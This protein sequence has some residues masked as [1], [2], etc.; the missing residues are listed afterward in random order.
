MNRNVAVE[1]AE[2]QRL[3]RELEEAETYTMTLR[4]VIVDVRDHLAAGNV[5]DAL[6]MLNEA[7]RNFDAQ[8]DVV[9]PHHQP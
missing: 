5:G 7:L 1:D 3:L 6:S 4:Q 2:A 8:T 9:V